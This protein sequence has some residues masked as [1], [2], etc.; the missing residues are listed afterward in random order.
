MS[1]LPHIESGMEWNETS[2]R[3]WRNVID[4]V[5]RLID[6]LGITPQAQ[7]DAPPDTFQIR[8][9]HRVA[10]VETI[11]ARER[12]YMM[13]RSVRY[14]TP[15]PREG[16]YAWVGPAFE[17]YPEIGLVLDDF[18]P[19]VWTPL[20]C[21]ET[22]EA[23]G[24]VL[25]RECMKR[26]GA[27]ESVC[28]ATADQ[29]IAACIAEN[30]E[31]EIRD[32]PP[33]LGTPI[34]DAH[35]QDGHW[36]VSLASGAGAEKLVVVRAFPKGDDKEPDP[37]SRFLIVQEVRPVIVDG[38]W[39]GTYEAFGDTAN[40]N[41]WPELTAGH[42]RPFLWEPAALQMKTT[43]M[44]LARIGG[45]WYCKQQPKIHVERATGTVKQMDCHK[46]E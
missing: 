40:V 28:R 12:P 25:F 45:V 16:Q 4:H 32:P 34:L 10:I 22:C 29:A 37:G 23:Q 7:L 3:E 24:E 36:L 20:S 11:D 5:Q 13:V 44:P 26:D 14:A 30:C 31:S 38:T 21:Q 18:L 1:D 46:L 8:R 15:P 33:T 27:V 41:V 39:T 43:I 6:A 35:W 2:A 42:Y 9:R 19:F 17:A